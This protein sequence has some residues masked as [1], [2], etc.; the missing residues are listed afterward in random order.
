M[1]FSDD[2]KS[3]LEREFPGRDIYKMTA[4]ELKVFKEDIKDKMHEC[5]MFSLGM[6]TLGNAAYGA[7][8]NEH[9]YFFDTRIAADIT[10]ECRNLTRT[11]WDKFEWFFKEELWLRTDLQ[12]KFNFRLDETKHDWYRSTPVSVYSDTDSVYT[13]YGN[14]FRA[15]TPETKALYDTDRKKVDWILKFNKEFLD[16]QNTEWCRDIFDP[17]HGHSV[18]EF[19]LETVSKAC[20]YQKKKKYIKAL[21]YSKGKY[22]DTPKIS[23][24]GIELVKTTTP[25][26]CRKMLTDLIHMLMFDYSDDIRREFMM[27]FR[28]KLLAYRKQFYGAPIEE[29]SQSI[30]IGDYH[31]YVIDDRDSLKLQPRC[32]SSVH[33]CARYNYLAHKNNEDN[34]R[35][36]SGKMKYYNISIS[37][38]NNG[39]FGYPSGELPAWAPKIDPLTQWSK[40]VIGPINRFM[41]AMK[42]DTMDTGTNI[43][44]SLF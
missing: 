15:M 3:F 13:S 5:D 40:N 39:Y 9:L 24:V 32:P 27:A 18:H 43:Q 28:Q 31:K 42:L 30:N 23:A 16:G 36:I 12:E 37:Y 29:I 38:K 44:L 4:Q 25:P 21:L 10:A 6:K 11:M 22:Y 8:A 2:V 7:S 1:E 17:R 20:I 34:K 41:E 35:M 26:L 19:E 14:L 33:A